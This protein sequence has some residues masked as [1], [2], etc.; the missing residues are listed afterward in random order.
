MLRVTTL[1]DIAGLRENYEVECKLAAGRNGQGEVPKDVWET[2]S[3]FANSDGGDIFLGLE[4]KQGTFRLNGIVNTTK[5]LDDFWNLINNSQKISNN[6]LKREHVSEIKLNGKIIIRIHVPRAMRKQRPVYIGNNPMTGTFK[7]QNS[8]DYRCDDETVRRMLAEQIEDSRDN[9]I[10][11]GYNMD[12]LDSTTFNAYRQLYVVRQPDH[13]WNTV[14]PIE[15]LRNIGAW[16][17][18]RESSKAGLTRAGLLMFGRLPSIQEHFP[19]YMLDYQERPEPNTEAR[20]ID[21][22]TLDGAW[23]G[24][25][26]DFYRQVFRK[27]TNRRHQTRRNA[28]ASGNT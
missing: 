6:I 15:F 5:V 21:R 18:D 4:E 23:S 11:F 27:L 10:L 1:D 9:E 12:D 17:A 24:N 8:G 26:F 7:R 20:W 22:I 28:C 13:P 16:R 3:A 2:Y 25:L 19:N 14:E